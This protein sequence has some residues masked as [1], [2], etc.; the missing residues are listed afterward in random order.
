MRIALKLA[1][2]GT[3]YHGFQVQPDVKTIEGELFRA[4]KE[5]KIINNPQEANYIAAGR[6]DKGV[7]ALGQ[8]IAFDTDNPR[9][10]IPR[11]INSM[12]CNIW[13]WASA[14]VSQDFDPR[15]DARYREYRYIMHGKYDLSTLRKAAKL[16]KG[17]HD[18]SNFATPEKGRTTVCRIEK[19]KIQA[20]KIFTIIDIRADRFLWHMVRK[21]ATAMKMIGSNER[22]LKWLENMLNL[23]C[24]EALE[25]AP[26]YGLILKNVE[27]ENIAWNEDS[28]A[29]KEML[30]SI[31]ELF[32]WHA[33]MAEILGELKEN[34]ASR[35]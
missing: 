29:K 1:Y 7:H 14:K 24:S 15:R 28:Y 27:Y 17:M 31:E 23:E 33:T 12:L 13:A 9:A 10:A 32:L 6:T 22:D 30:E 20:K 26:A 16:L 18:F 8:V 34:Y 35:I 25:P 5:L 4:L 21:L 2:L 11:A 3:D 19:M